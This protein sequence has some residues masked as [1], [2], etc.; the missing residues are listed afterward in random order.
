MVAMVWQCGCVGGCVILVIV[1]TAPGPSNE[2]FGRRVMT[3]LRV[4]AKPSTDAS[5]ISP[6]CRVNKFHTYSCM[7]SS[8]L[9]LIGKHS[10]WLLVLTW[11]FF[12]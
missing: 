5:D 6:G 8:T 10:N 4:G 9:P 3:Q 7:F 1:V 2:L 11:P 12:S